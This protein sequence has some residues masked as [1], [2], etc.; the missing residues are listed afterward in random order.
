[1]E[2]GAGEAER[3]FFEERIASVSPNLLKTLG[4]EKAGK[5]GSCS[6]VSRCQLS[7]HFQAAEAARSWLMV[8]PLRHALP[9]CPSLLFRARPLSREIQNRWTLSKPP[10][11]TRI[12]SFSED[13]TISKVTF[14]CSLPTRQLVGPEGAEGCRWVWPLPHA[15]C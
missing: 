7:T 1:M 15:A 9:G 5:S 12:L 13:P 3:N 6:Q 8:A 10:A 11:E 4:L 2:R 14:V